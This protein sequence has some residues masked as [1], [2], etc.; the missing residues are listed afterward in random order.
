[1]H[2]EKRLWTPEEKVKSRKEK[3]SISLLL[4]SSKC[5]S[6]CQEVNRVVTAHKM[7]QFA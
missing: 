2:L 3:K 1:M 6:H 5:W 7:M 4:K